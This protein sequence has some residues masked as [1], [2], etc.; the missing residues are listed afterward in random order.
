M[1]T[2]HVVLDRSG[3]MN[4]VKDDTIG[5]F[6][7]YVETLRGQEPE[8]ILSLTLF[9]SGGIDTIINM[10]K[11]KEVKAL[12]DKEYQPR[13]MTPLY[14]AIGKVVQRLEETVGD[15]KVLVILT[16]GE[17]NSSREFSKEAIRKLLDEKQE[18]DNWLV[19]YLGANQDAFKEGGQIGTQ[20]TNTLNFSMDNMQATMDV[21]AASSLRY[22]KTSD[23]LQAGFSEQERAKV[24]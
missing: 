19:L 15:N 4:S 18:K 10:Q 13:S 5:A 9:D 1:L 17:E 8:S 23:R 24:R 3:S 22:A 2:V 16:D 14:D 21:A 20:D 11:I 7:S 12:T 6:N